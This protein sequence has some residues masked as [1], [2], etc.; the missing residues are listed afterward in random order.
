MAPAAA[1]GLRSVMLRSRVR[2]YPG[3]RI[4]GFGRAAIGTPRVLRM[5]M[6]KKIH[7][8]TIQGQT[9]TRESD[10]REYTH[11]VYVVVTAAE[12]DAAIANA[13][14]RVTEG[15]AEIAR[16][17]PLAAAP[18]DQA[19]YERT[20]AAVAYLEEQV[21]NTDS[22]TAPGAMTSRWLSREY[23]E[24]VG[25]VAGQTKF[26]ALDRINAAGNAWRATAGR[27]LDYAR[28]QLAI[29]QRYLESCREIVIGKIACENWS[30]SSH[31]AGKLADDLK[32]RR[33]HADI[34]IT[35]AVQIRERA[36]RAKRAS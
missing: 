28:S 16:L 14:R 19:E 23:R 33:P 31:G 17:E 1:P 32:R 30:S 8:V 24:S 21:P 5:G 7:T 36:T 29:D 35:D 9:F 10:S 12:R 26:I 13:T 3:C 11:A 2:E 18:A 4:A 20:R 22:N 15:L 6:G 25:E 34:K 27:K